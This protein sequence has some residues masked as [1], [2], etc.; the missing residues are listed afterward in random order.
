MVRN[1]TLK[2]ASG[3][4][5]LTKLKLASAQS[6]TVW[7]AVSRCFQVQLVFLLAAVHGNRT[8]ELLHQ[9]AD[10]SAA[11]FVSCL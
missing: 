6:L 1:P 10:I 3:V 5:K 4:K 11:P 7:T 2:T 9:P 8:Y